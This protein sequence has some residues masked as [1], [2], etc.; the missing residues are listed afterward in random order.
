MRIL[1]L[2][3]SLVLAS[4]ALAKDDEVYKWVDE[5]GVIHY[6]D[7][8]PRKDAEPAKL[9]PLQTYKGGT[10][11]DLRRF[12]KG[13]RDGTPPAGAAQVQ[14][15]T[16][17]RDETFRSAERVVPIAVMVTPSLRQGH[18]LI[19][20]VDGKPVSMPTTDT[21]FA[22]TGVNRGSHSVVVT[23]VDDAGEELGRSQPVT[24]HM[25]PP[26]AR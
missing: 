3:L 8:P 6:T 15:V 16:P 21:S 7:K 11:P 25:K 26:T 9:P 22:V 10:A 24:F 2:L 14:I 18:K 23:L 20:M 12:D 17:A 19:Y 1:I 5:N 4:S 13:P